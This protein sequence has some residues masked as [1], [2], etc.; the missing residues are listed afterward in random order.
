VA[1]EPEQGRVSLWR[2]RGW[3]VELTMAQSVR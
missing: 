3:R 2:P 1:L